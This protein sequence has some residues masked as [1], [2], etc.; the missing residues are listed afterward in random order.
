VVYEKG[1]KR[2]P[3]TFIDKIGEPFVELE[4]TA[5]P[6]PDAKSAGALPVVNTAPVREALVGRLPTPLPPAVSTPLIAQPRPEDDDEDDF[7]LLS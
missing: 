6:V 4:K 3:K 2:K 1:D 7:L 5:E